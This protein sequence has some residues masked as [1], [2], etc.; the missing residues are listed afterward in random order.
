MLLK[1]QQWLKEET[2]LVITFVLAIASSFI[3]APSLGY[4]N[5]I[6]WDTLA[7]LLALMIV[8]AGFKALGLFS[9]LGEMLLSKVKSQRAIEIVLIMACFFSSMIITNDVALI[10]FVPFAIETLDYRC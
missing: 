1:F 10:T 7:L 4:L 3:V 9:K 6:D 2:L 5:Y 8:M